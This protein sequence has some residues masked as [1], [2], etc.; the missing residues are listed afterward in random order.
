MVLSR[1]FATPTLAV[2]VVLLGCQAENEV[3]TAPSFAVQAAQRPL[4]WTV[5][6]LPCP[7]GTAPRAGAGA[8]AQSVVPL[9]DASGRLLIGSSGFCSGAEQP[10]WTPDW[11]VYDISSGTPVLVDAFDAQSLGYN[12]GAHSPLG[13]RVGF[14]VE[15]PALVIYDNGFRKVDISSVLEMGNG[16]WAASPTSVWIVG[17]VYA[18][19]LAPSIGRII[20]YDG[21]S[22][23]VEYEGG[24][25]LWQV[26][27]TGTSARLA[28]RPTTTIGGITTPGELL[29]RQ[30]DGTWMPVQLPGGCDA[31]AW[32]QNAINGLRPND[33]W[34]V[35]SCG[36]LH[37][38]G[39]QWSQ[40][41]FPFPPEGAGWPHNVVPLGGNS[42]LVSGYVPNSSPIPVESE[43][44][45]AWASGDG[46]Q[47]WTQVG[48]AVFQDLPSIS[49]NFFAA[50]GTSG[51]R[52]VYL[53]PIYG[54]KLF[55]GSVMNPNA[56]SR[57]RPPT[58]S[59]TSRGPG[60]SIEQ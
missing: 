20:H 12:I 2:L 9:G 37:F 15:G 49:R 46:G 45:A 41:P 10:S 19:P 36:L 14:G 35:A 21:E 59:A 4:N 30:A 27:G 23:Q 7:E 17:E 29:E 18:D 56:L 57:G 40:V 24:L 55:V 22:F 43:L 34:V 47:T 5:L 6:D 31:D 38:D 42:L 39:R 52:L 60:V 13:T 11:Y 53:P 51:G 58:A 3:P 1:R 16:V 25:P 54:M 32:L 8:Q 26:W 44:I 28:S 33:V 48:D 50:T